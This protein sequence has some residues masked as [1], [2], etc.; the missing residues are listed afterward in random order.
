MLAAL[1]GG[2][3]DP[4]ILANL[5][6]GKLK[7]KRAALREALTGRVDEHHTEITRRLLEEIDG[8]STKIDGLTAC[9]DVLVAKLPQPQ[10]PA[11][12]D[13]RC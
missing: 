9:I 10:A 3:R 7:N 1:I 11:G 13:P 8:L 6:V 4:E 12:G 5:S 2:E